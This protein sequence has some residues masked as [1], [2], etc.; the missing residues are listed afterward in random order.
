MSA[1]SIWVLE[2]AYAPEYPMSGLVYGAHNEG[3]TKLPYCYAVIKGNGHNI[4]VDVGYNYRD[5]GKVVAD[6][7]GVIHWHSPREVLAEV[8]LR[9]EDIDTILITHAHFDH[10][11]NVADF[12]NAT[13]Y[14]QEVEVS[15]WIWAMSL[16]QQFEW[17]TG[18]VD[19]G[20]ILRGVE[21]SKEQ[22]LVLVNGDKTDVV[23]GI[24]LFAAFDSHTFGSQ[25][26][27]V[28][29]GSDTDSWVLA[30]D[31]VYVF[32]NTQGRN[33]SNAYIPIG[34]AT[35]SQTNLLLTT[36][37]MMNLVGRDFKR[38]IPVHEERLGTIFPARKSSKGLN[39][40]EVALA[41]GETSR[42]K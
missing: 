13:V 37:K 14:M 22:R 39:V 21:L 42:V 40:V 26:I 17:L 15:K 8:G 31:L 18:A 9:P 20:D 27:R 25:F 2:Y 11:G 38:I 33:G 10:F 24:D 23:P 32:E 3:T 41:A 5:Y 6:R 36:E 28:R 1:Y 7:F 4:M 19:P 12:P 29:N 16:P 30:G 35:G 34:L